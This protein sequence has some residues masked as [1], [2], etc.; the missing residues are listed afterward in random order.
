MVE[1]WP[2]LL[3]P[4]IGPYLIRFIHDG[5]LV[6]FR[7]TKPIRGRV[8]RGISSSSQEKKKKKRSTLVSSANTSSVIFSIYSTFL[9]CVALCVSLRLGCVHLWVFFGRQILRLPEESFL[10]LGRHLMWPWEWMQAFG[11]VLP[12]GL[13][14]DPITHTLLLDLDETALQEILTS[15]FFTQVY[16]CI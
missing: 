13:Y 7:I 12:K 5:L 2:A 15:F 10:C 8:E 1:E 11:E 6:R 16:M 14:K 3:L 4:L 9:S